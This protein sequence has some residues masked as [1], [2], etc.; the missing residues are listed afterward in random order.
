[1]LGR[2]DEYRDGLERAFDQHRESGDAQRAARCAFWIGHNLLFRGDS[3]RAAGW[4]GRAERLIDADGRDCVE[5]GYL[6]IPLWLGQMARDEWQAGYDTAAAA[7]EIAERFADADLVWLARDEQSRALLN[8]GRVQEALRLADEVL[9][10]APD[11]SPVVSGILYCNTV[12]FCQSAYQ[13]RHA[14][15]WTEALTT[16]CEERPGMVAH[17]GLCL[18]HRA[19]V[20]RL[21]GDWT[22]AL[23]EVTRAADRFTDGVL[24]ELACGSAHYEQGEVHR[25]RGTAREAETA[26]RAA[27]QCGHE[28]QPGLALL[29]L[30]TGDTAA[31]AAAIRRAV[32]E[33][34]KPLR[35]A[36]LLPA[37]VEI[38]VAA[39]ELERARGA[40]ADLEELAGAHASEALAAMAD[41]AHGAVLLAVG[42]PGAALARLRAAADGWRSLDARY[43]LA[44]A[45]ELLGLACRGMSDEDSAALEL[46]AAL[47]AFEQ[48]GAAP[49][50]RR[51]RTQL[52]ATTDVHGLS[53]RELEVLRLVAA[54][55]SNRDIATALVISEH[56]VARHLQN[57]YAKLGV[58]S[59]TAAGA[60]AYEHHLTGPN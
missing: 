24:N 2:D 28:P 60:F 42:E 53:E 5:R 25:L 35:R 50:A 34:T 54:G 3:V 10:A 56:T 19:Q 38:M 18:V 32:A 1:M 12:A 13:L 40:C 39:G 20:M 17:M 52:R 9:L 8:L 14:Q 15:A 55:D 4:F 47:E 49:D 26:Y 59:R 36:R 43:E 6:L 31:A 23:D 29:R 27:S 44:R 57:I 41:H 46:E 16:W 48:L 45:R 58:S 51:V 22:G 21:H 11:L 30:A 37:Y 33:T 7:A